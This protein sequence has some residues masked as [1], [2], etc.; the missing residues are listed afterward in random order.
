M[1]THSPSSGPASS[2]TIERRQEH[3][4]D[5][6][7]EAEI[8]QRQEV[9]RR[10]ATIST[11]RAS[12]SPNRLVV[13]RALALMMPK[14]GTSTSSSTNWPMKRDHT[15]CA[16]GMPSRV[17]RYF[18]AVSRPENKHDRRHHQADGLRRCRLVSSGGGE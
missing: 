15:T 5:R 11:E 17:T 7:I 10:R 3:D 4:G 13:N 9:E 12:C 18:A 8:A 6:L 14:A 2:A 16:T 1:P